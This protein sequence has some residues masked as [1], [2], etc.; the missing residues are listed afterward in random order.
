[1][2]KIGLRNGAARRQ[3]RSVLLVSLCCLGAA[4]NAQ[5]DPPQQ[6]ADDTAQPLQEIVVTATKHSES[7]LKVPLSMTAIDQDTMNQQNVK[8]ISDIARLVPGLNLQASDDDG[9]TNISIRGISSDVGSATTGIY[10]DDVPVQ[11]RQEAVST[12]PYPKIVDLD[13]VEVLRGPQGTL[14]GAGSEGGTVRFI[15]PDASLQ[16]YSGFLRGQV[17]FTVG[18]DPSYETTAAVGG[19]IVDGKVGFRASISHLDDGGYIDRLN[20]VT[21]QVEG[22][23]TNN[24][25]STAVQIKFKLAPTDQLIITPSVFYQDVRTDDKSLYW[26]KAGQFNELAAIPQ[27]N[28]DHFIIPSLG[29][30]YNFDAFSVKSIT[31]YLKRAVN[32]QYDSTA[33]EMSS[34]LPFGISLPGDPG[35]HSVANYYESQINF[36]QEFRVT[37]NDT[38]NSVLSWVG[39]LFYEHARAGANSTYADPHF[40]LISNYLSEFYYK[41]PST[42]AE[43][44]GENLIDG[45]YSYIDHFIETETDMAAYGNVTYSILPD[46]K[47]SAGLRVARSGFTYF[48]ASDG[49]WGA[50]EYLAYS[51]SEKETPVTPRFSLTYQYDPNQMVYTTVA[52]GYRIGGANE[53]V[54]VNSAIPDSCVG[55]LAKL[56]LKQVPAQYNS[57]S[58]WSYEAGAKG[59]YFDNKVLLETSIFWV[60][61]SQIQ[62]SVYLPTCSYYYIYNLG[63]AASR[64]VDLQAQW[65]VTKE[66]VL[67]GTAGLTDA[68]YTKSLVVD[69]QV[70][71]K[72]G[73]PLATPEWT[74]TIAAEYTRDIM[75]ETEGYFRL[76]YEFSGGY[77]RGGSA[78]TFGY[79]AQTRDAPATHFVTLR[80]GAR[81]DGWDVSLYVDNLLN[82]NTSLFR[83][84]DTPST[85]GFRDT[86]FRPLTAGLTAEY[87]F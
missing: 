59:R 56:G 54:P 72:A 83:F 18:G 38:P 61:W 50:A 68:R 21:N 13:R 30:E 75:P 8:D 77:F 32:D 58:V 76:D 31:S 47:A 71:A 19:P 26:E 82:S 29:I 62:Q 6:A 43:Y 15:T 10:I 64:G 12:N 22:T 66:L 73:D 36:T 69:N 28:N 78:V 3:Y 39:G 81:R 42:T 67:S 45:K 20:P 85:Y 2:N 9:D 87:K 79:D 33:Y 16:S 5:A 27:P 1:V 60:D 55:D 63:Q 52:K 65:S 7:I 4:A 25:A 40:D 48:D 49:P 51:G 70:L 23:N 84:R 57:D 14:F 24:V 74:A 41:T 35:Y 37:S 80:T 46:L 44:W 86:T 53:P 17:A 34:I 11:A